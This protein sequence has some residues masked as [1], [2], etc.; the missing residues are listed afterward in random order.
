MQQHPVQLA[1]SATPV[2]E[3]LSPDFSILDAVSSDDGDSCSSSGDSDA[4]AAIHETPDD[5]V[6]ASSS[7]G[8]NWPQSPLVH[9]RNKQAIHQVNLAM[10]STGHQTEL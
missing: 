2:R 6:F 3:K 7:D 8:A 9:S 1:Q 5:L 4:D 10:E